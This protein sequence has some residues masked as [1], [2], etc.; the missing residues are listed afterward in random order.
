MKLEPE[1]ARREKSEVVRWS[2]MN[3]FRG[4]KPESVK[5]EIGCMWAMAGQDGV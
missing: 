1:I 5:V 4:T 3:S 2:R